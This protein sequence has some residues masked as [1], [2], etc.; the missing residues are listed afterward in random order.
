MSRYR[1][2]AMAAVGLSATV[3]AYA[4]GDGATEPTPTRDPS[5]PTTVTVTPASAE[6]TAIGATVHL[7]AQVLDQN[8]QAMA[9]AAVTWS[10]GATSVATVSAAG[11]VTAA[12][13]GTATI[14]ATAGSASG[15]ASITVAQEVGAVTVTPAAD[16][17]LA[18]GDTLRL[19]AEASDANGHVVEGTAFRWVSADTLVAIVDSTGLVTGIEPGEVS[20]TATAGSASGTASITVAQEVGAVTVTPAADTLLALGDT[21]RLSAEASDANG[22]VVEGTAFRWVS[23]DTLV[24]IVDSTG[25]VTGIEPGEVSVTATAAGVSG[26]AELTVAAPVPTTLSVTPDTVAFTAIGQSVQLAAEVLDQARRAMEHVQVSWSSADTTVATVDS[27]GLVTA[28]RSGTTTVTASASEASGEAVVTVMQSTGSV[29]VSPSADTVALGD[30]LRLVA[31]AFDENGHAVEDAEFSWSSSNGSVVT[32]DASGLVTG[33]AEGMAEIT[34]GAGDAQGT[35]EITVENPDRAALVALYNA[36]DGPNWVNSE[37]WL[38]EAPLG[39]WYGVDTDASGRV[40]GL[41]LGGQR[42][43]DSRQ[44]IP[45]GLAGPIPPELGNLTELT[46]LN[47]RHNALVGPIPAE[48]GRLAR[49]TRLDLWRNRLTGPIPSELGA[50][51]SLTVLWLSDN[52]LSGAIPLELGRLGDLR[53]LGLAGNRLADA[54]PPELGNLAKL[55]Q[56]SLGSNQLSGPVPLEL[57]KLARLRSLDL[58]YNDLSGPIPESFFKLDGLRY[59]YFEE[60]AGLCAPGTSA[61]VT[62]LDTIENRDEGL[63][64]N[65]A[66]AVVLEALHD[67]SGGREWTNSEGWLGTP[68]LAQWHGVTADSLGRVVTLD[69]TRNGLTGQLPNNLGTLAG[70]TILRIGDN[71]LSGRLPSSLSSLSLVELDYADTELCAPSDESFQTWLAGIPSHEGTGEE[72]AP[73][74]ER[75]ILE[76]FYDATGGPNWTNND[77]WLTDAPLRTWHGVRVNGQGRVGR[78]SLNSNNL[79][80]S[81]PPELGS[82]A[83]LTQLN[84][85]RNAVTGEIPPALGN[86]SNLTFLALGGNALEG[87]IPPELGNLTGLWRLFLWRNDLSGPIPPELGNLSKLDYLSLSTNNLTGTIPPELGN[88]SSVTE[89]HLQANALTGAIPGQLG[90]LT[91]AEVIL[92]WGNALTGEIPSE[93]GNLPSARV[94]SLSDN[95]LSGPIPAALGNLPS[96]TYLALDENA[97]PGDLP[98]QLGNLSTVEELFLDNND[99]SGQVPPEFG[100]M[101]NLTELGLANNSGME[102]PL[103]TALTALGQ[104]EAL[105]A[106]GTQLCAPSDPAFQAWLERVHK[107]RL[108]PCA[109]GDPPTAYMVQAVQSWEFPVPLVA[110]EDALLRVFVTATTGTSASIPAV[111]ARFFRNGRETHVEEIP[112]KPAPIPTELDESSLSKSANAEIPGHVIQPGLEMVIEVDPDNTLNPALGVAKRI[113]ATGRLAVDVRAMPLFDLTLIPFIWTESH[114]SSIVDLVK[115]MAAD[116]ESHEMLSDTRTLLP[117]GD[118]VVTAHEPVMTSS[119]SAFVLRD[120]AKAIRAMEGGTGHYMA[121]MSRPVTGAGGVAFLPGRASFSLP[122]ASTIAHELGHNMNLQHAPCGTSGDP[123]YP[124]LDGSIGAWGYDFRDG[125]SLVRPS[126]PDLMSYCF[127]SRWISDFSFTNSLRYRLFDEGPPA[128]AV[129]TRSLL[130]WG[131]IGADSVLYLEP[132]FVIEAPPTLPDSAGEYG[133]TGRSENG[134]E[135]FSLAFTMPVTADGDGSSSFA[136]VLPVRP[137]WEHRLASVTLTAPDGSTT[138]NRDSDLPMAILRNPRTGQIR[139]ILRDPPLATQAAADAGTARVQGLDVMYS[140]GI[141]DADAWRR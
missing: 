6:L 136:F 49:L 101:S 25:L 86:L 17:L 103:P 128:A 71:A 65:A 107:R 133:L 35:S 55:W 108:Q 29:V 93:L 126:R 111:R 109:E 124:Y 40:V 97:L 112:G 1:I 106:G 41:D 52:D 90:R 122:R 85:T 116:A 36:T 42:D 134:A 104:V 2:F 131:G 89:L 115:A 139:G 132:T 70:M 129:A 141:P 80:G 3:W 48:L 9:G 51:A 59:F 37:K 94:L 28:V 130:L 23:A 20:V 54:I 77:N 61:F 64:C 18:L 96:V 56:L 91:T 66:D 76:I 26:H 10:S 114:D 57:G 7:A 82:L 62:W 95:Q 5:R 78:L 83:N 75:E 60:N 99:L 30:T 92:L 63:Y 8:G 19:S 100:R 69:L 120:Q 79:T 32:V 44:W 72:C 12:G 45:H 16:T 119:N 53:N 21:L 13:N 33:V 87:P 24:A 22:H 110:D 50:L 73:L 102:G 27:A 137:G 14:T 113:P 117:V 135:L 74:T 68:A 118:L 15:T 98:P 34:A 138:L 81:I 39:E 127:Q 105:M 121:M 46:E 47:L 140:R 88:L 67:A 84:L 11:V 123:S 43:E 4:C 38:T 31:E 58:G 125:G